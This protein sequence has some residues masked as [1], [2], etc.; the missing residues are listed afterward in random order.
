MV[1]ALSSSGGWEVMMVVVGVSATAIKLS[2][3]ALVWWGCMGA[4]KREKIREDG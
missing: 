4:M 2:P 1:T 3:E